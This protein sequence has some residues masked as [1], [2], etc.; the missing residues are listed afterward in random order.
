LD[1]PSGLSGESG[2]LDRTAVAGSWA[3]A[4]A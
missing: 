1:L 2:D 4:W 3:F